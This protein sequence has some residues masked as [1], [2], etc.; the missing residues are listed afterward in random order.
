M[1]GRLLLVASIWILA[2]A[3]AATATSPS[4]PSE[5][6]VNVLNEQASEDE[7]LLLTGTYDAAHCRTAACLAVDDTYEAI[8][9]LHH[10]DVPNGLVILDIRHH[11]FGAP[12]R[13]VD[14][15]LRAHPERNPYRCA[16][17]EKLARHIPPGDHWPHSEAPRFMYE[18]IDL[19]SRLRVHGANCMTLVLAALPKTGAARELVERARGF[20]RHGRYTPCAKVRLS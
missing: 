1:F 6:Y 10:R 7:L 11:D 19:A 15:I 17:L 3:V 8:R 16:I 9:F 14:R 20:C 4:G 5:A 12:D 2:P 13:A 18:V